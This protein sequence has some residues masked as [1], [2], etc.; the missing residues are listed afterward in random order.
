[1]L[2]VVR[3][4]LRRR[5]R[6]VE[7]AV[8]GKLSAG[9][10]SSRDRWYPFSSSAKEFSREIHHRPSRSFRGLL[11]TRV[12]IGK[13]NMVDFSAHVNASR[14]NAFPIAPTNNN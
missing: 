13:A 5:L 11:E 14:E 12:S 9:G 4:V 1:M 10:R 7:A 6:K 8:E 3:D 2:G